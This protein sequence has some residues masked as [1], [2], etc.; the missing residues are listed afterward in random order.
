MST[1]VTLL[2]KHED[3]HQK[4]TESH[5]CAECGK[6]FHDKDNL[7]QHKKSCHE[8]NENVGDQ[9]A[10]SNG[11]AETL[12]QH[13]NTVQEKAQYTCDQCDFNEISKTSVSEHVESVHNDTKKDK[14]QYVSK[15]IKCEECGKKF[16]KKE[17]FEKHRKQCQNTILPYVKKLQRTLRSNKSDN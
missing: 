11:K 5:K 12:K 14:T 6:Q 4:K 8:R 7:I 9:C 13:N 1:S 15:R 3:S 17:T 10:K 16:N 2:K